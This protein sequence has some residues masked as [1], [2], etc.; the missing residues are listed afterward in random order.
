MKIKSVGDIV[1]TRASNGRLIHMELDRISVKR[2]GWWTLI[3]AFKF[4]A[5]VGWIVRGMK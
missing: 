1:V 5:V 4:G 3:L 2:F